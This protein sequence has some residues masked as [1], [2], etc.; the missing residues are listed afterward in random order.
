MQSKSVVG[1]FTCLVS[2]AVWAR[3]MSRRL[4]RRLSQIVRVGSVRSV[5]FFLT[6]TFEKRL[7]V[8]EQERG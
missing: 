8:Q 7:I 6:M 4:V 3:E 5:V 1:R 2:A